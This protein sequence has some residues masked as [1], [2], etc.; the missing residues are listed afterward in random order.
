MKNYILPLLFVQFLSL[1]AFSKGDGYSQN[2][3][4]GYSISNT[5]YHLSE[6]DDDDD[7]DDKR[8]YRRKCDKKYRKDDCKR[9]HHSHECDDDDDDDR[10]YKKNRKKS[11]DYPRKI[12]RRRPGIIIDP[13]V[14]II[15]L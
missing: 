8:K 9:R 13:G 7:D 6:E 3:P 14:I 5:N 4:S 2:H 11:C 1:T 12:Y 15:R 10:C